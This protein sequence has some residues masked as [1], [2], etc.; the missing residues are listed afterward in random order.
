MCSDG[1]MNILEWISKKGQVRT[2]ENT[3]TYTTARQVPMISLWDL[4]TSLFP[5][6]GI[7]NKQI[8]ETTI[9]CSIPLGSSRAGVTDNL[10]RMDQDRAMV[11][12]ADDATWLSYCTFGCCIVLLDVVPLEIILVCSICYFISWNVKGLDVPKNEVIFATFYTCI[13]LTL[14][15]FKKLNCFSI[16]LF[17]SISWRFLYN[18]LE[19]LG[20][21]GGQ[22]IEWQ[23]NILDCISK[24]AG[25]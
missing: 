11:C 9:P 17:L 2:L 16:R 14:F 22:F 5:Y 21:S 18:R 7:T 10:R 3:P 1:P 6:E 12:S 8:M 15:Y 13:V 20:A 25:D 24:L 23:Y 19:S 4:C